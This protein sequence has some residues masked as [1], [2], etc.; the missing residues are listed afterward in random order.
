MTVYAAM[1]FLSA[2][3]AL[4]AAFAAVE[5]GLVSIIVNCRRFSSLKK[6]NPAG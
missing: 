1:G 4:L 3:A 5:R 6:N 2:I